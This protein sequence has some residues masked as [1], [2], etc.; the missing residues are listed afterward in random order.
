MGKSSHG[1]IFEVAATVVSHQHFSGK[2]HILKLQAPV[3]AQTAKPGTF[4]HMQCGPELLL[5]RPL[6]IMRVSASQGWIELLY[7]EV[8]KGT[9]LLANRKENDQVAVLGPIGQPFEIHDDRPRRLLIGGGVGLPP[10]VFLADTLKNRDDISKSFA[11][12]GSEVAFPFQA[13]PSNIII[14]GIPEDTIATMPLLENWGLACRLCSL[15]GYSGCYNGYVTKLARHWLEAL[16]SAQRKQVEI[17][18]CGPH[19]MLESVAKLSQEYNI[20]CQVS[21]E[22][23]MACAVGGCAGCVVKI[24]TGDTVAMKRVCV[25]GPVFD[26]TTVFYS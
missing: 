19:A 2:Q 12:L 4:V 20:A 7:K 23:F 15:Q 21:L 24:K 25:D 3:I 13:M 8:G 1:S 18:S 22:E 5:R 26:A 10:M 14:P 16:D 11:I 17:F 9:R 6:S